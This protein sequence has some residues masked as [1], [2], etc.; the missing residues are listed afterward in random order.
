MPF[1]TP[2]T[3]ATTNAARI[4]FRLP[5]D[6]SMK[7]RCARIGGFQSR[8]ISTDQ[9]CPVER[10]ERC[11]TSLCHRQRSM[12]AQHASFRAQFAAHQH[13]PANNTNDPKHGLYMPRLGLAMCAFPSMLR[14]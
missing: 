2:R 6:Q 4:N 12:F 9:V 3:H 14:S 5:F 11:S 10:P 13:F 7:A 8:H 1:S